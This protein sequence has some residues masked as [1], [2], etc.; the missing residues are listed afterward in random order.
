MEGGRVKREKELEEDP[1]PCEI[2][3]QRKRRLG[4]SSKRRGERERRGNE[5]GN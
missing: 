4:P 2:W 1:N 5:T 3:K